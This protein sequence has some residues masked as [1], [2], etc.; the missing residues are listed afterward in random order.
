MKDNGELTR[1]MEKGFSI[2][3]MEIFTRAVGSMIRLMAKGFI[4]IQTE[5]NMLDNGKI[6]ISTALE[7]KNGLM[8]KNM[9]DSIEMV[10]KL[11]RVLSAFQIQVTMKGNS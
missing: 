2:T 8:A 4:P 1:Q 5:P 7:Y 11:E 3:Q 9:K 6:I 10:L